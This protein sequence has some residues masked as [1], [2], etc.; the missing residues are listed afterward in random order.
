MWFR[1]HHGTIND[2]KLGMIAKITNTTVA[3]VVAV[4][5]SLLE[6]ASAQDDT[7]GT[8][9]EIAGYEPETMDYLLMLDDGMTQKI[10]D[11][12]RARGM[13]SGDKITS[14]GKRQVKR[15]RAE[16]M[17]DYRERGNKP[18]TEPSVTKCNRDEPS[19]TKCNLDKSRLDKS[20][21]KSG[22]DDRKDLLDTLSSSESKERE[23]V[24]ESSSTGDGTKKRRRSEAASPAQKS[25]TLAQVID[26]WNENLAT[27]GFSKALKSTSK[28]RAAFNAR[29][30]EDAERKDIEWWVELMRSI[31]RS[32]FL[33]DNAGS[34]WLTIDWVLN[35]SNLTKIVEGKYLRSNGKRSAYDRLAEIDPDADDAAPA[36]INIGSVDF[37][38]VMEIGQG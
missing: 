34:N 16:Y 37:T 9:G 14:W 5:A 8:R 10:V 25:V 2:P 33:R 26:A 11:A 6:C 36:V 29:L 13:L 38:E 15:E 32:K 19:V 17:A 3:N 12:M 4:W 7:G 24:L 1:W 21:D 31:Y 23:I 18:N 30:A 22:V 35:E 20:K 27:R 28:R